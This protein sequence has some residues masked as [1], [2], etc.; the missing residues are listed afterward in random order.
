MSE[1]DNSNEE[2][3][4]LEGESEDVK[5]QSRVDKL[6]ENF[7][8][9][10]AGGEFGDDMLSNSQFDGPIVLPTDE[11][12]VEKAMETLFK[13]RRLEVAEEHGI[14]DES[15]IKRISP[16]SVDINIEQPVYLIHEFTNELTRYRPKL[17]DEIKSRDGDENTNPM[18]D[19]K[20]PIIPY[21]LKEQVGS[22]INVTVFG[23]A[24]MVIYNLCNKMNY[25][26]DEREFILNASRVAA[27]KNGLHSHVL[28][29]DTAFAPYKVYET[30]AERSQARNL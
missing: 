9:K 12:V 6:V 11:K 23:G 2:T 7:Q 13:E 28:I 14:T 21:I 30:P 5:L 20:D 25:T 3:P 16:E 15:E 19:G 1:S 18:T 29:D 8:E 4:E 26:K 22:S 24:R 10:I 17:V 27:Q